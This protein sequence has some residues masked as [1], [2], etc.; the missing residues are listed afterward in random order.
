MTRAPVARHLRSATVALFAAACTGTSDGTKDE[1]AQNRISEPVSPE[2][3]V[4]LVE[5][6]RIG[7]LLDGDEAEHFS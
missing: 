3:R 7:S 6:L 4:S 1:V 5:E 2:Q